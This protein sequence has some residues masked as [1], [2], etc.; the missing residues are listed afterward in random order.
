METWRQGITC[1]GRFGIVNLTFNLISCYDLLWKRIK[2]AK[3]D[4]VNIL[5]NDCSDILIPPSCEKQLQAIVEYVFIYKLL[6]KIYYS[7][8]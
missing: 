7:R 5:I 4:F 8:W 1:R 2:I 3:R 6:I